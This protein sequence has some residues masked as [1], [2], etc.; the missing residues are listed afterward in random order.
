MFEK[1][2]EDL[3]IVALTQVTSHNVMVLNE[4]LLET[5]SKNIKLKDEIVSL[6]EETKKRRKVEDSM[7]PLL[8]GVKIPHNKGRHYLF[9][10][11]QLDSQTF[12]M[13]GSTGLWTRYRLSL[14]GCSWL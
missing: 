7:I 9:H 2:D 14:V 13:V 1:I 10:K 6:G 5:K 8:T 3:V 4:K 11:S 12:G